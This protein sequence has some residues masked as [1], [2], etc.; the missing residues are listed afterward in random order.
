M[1][2]LPV[3]NKVSE[4]KE[5]GEDI[6]LA[7][8]LLPDVTPFLDTLS[9]R[10]NLYGIV[11]VPYSSTESTV[12]KIRSKHDVP[13][14]VPSSVQEVK[15]KVT[16]LV[17]QYDDNQ[18]VIVDTGGYCVAILKDKA[19]EKLLGI[20]EDTNQGHW[21][22]EEQESDT[23]IYS[24]AQSTIKSLENKAVGQAIVFS[25]ENILRNELQQDLADKN[26]LVMGYGG[27]GKAV[28]TSLEGR[29]AAVYVYDKNPVKM[30]EARLDGYQSV[31]KQRMLS[32]ADVIIGASGHESL[33]QDELE[34]LSD[35]TILVSESSKQVEIDTEY[36]KEQTSLVREGFNW[37]EYAD[38]EMSV[39]LLN[40]GKPINFLDN[41]VPL[42]IL[43]L[44][45]SELYLC[46][47][48]ITVNETNRSRRIGEVSQD[49]KALITEEWLQQYG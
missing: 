32:K 28:T 40:E 25:T 22:Y 9:N 18:L 46:I 21:K 44:I 11:G 17:D 41:S 10:Y 4:T 45:F 31:E 30:V 6:L 8:H 3:L 36:L 15:Q 27:I 43:D 5:S 7:H 16:D 1:D 39:T 13:V 42:S 38:A 48:E 49:K 20:V 29:N 23:Q 19:E 12:K 14:T 26:V 47:E 24:I 37:K 2:K 34:N 35:Q 33:G